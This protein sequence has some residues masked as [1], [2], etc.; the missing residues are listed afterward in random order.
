MQIIIKYQQCPCDTC[1]ALFVAPETDIRN[2]IFE[3]A[4]GY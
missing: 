4:C 1:L 2:G 3:G